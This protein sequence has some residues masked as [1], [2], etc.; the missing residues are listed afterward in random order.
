MPATLPTPLTLRVAR[1]ITNGDTMP[2]RAQGSPNRA[3]LL[4]SA[5]KRGSRPWVL[6]SA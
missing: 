1:R 5:R 3:M 6:A 2:I 4:S